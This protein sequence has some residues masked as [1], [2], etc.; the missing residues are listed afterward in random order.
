MKVLDQYFSILF[1]KKKNKYKGFILIFIQMILSILFVT[2]LYKIDIIPEKYIISI[3]IFLVVVLAVNFFIRLNNKGKSFA[4]SFFS[5]TI[6]ILLSF[7]I[8]YVYKI[9][10]AMKEMSSDD[11]I[12]NSDIEK[13]FNI[14]IS[15][16]DVYGDIETS[17]RSDVN[18]I[19][20]VN[21]KTHQILLT[22]TPRDFYV[23]IPGI[24]NGQK[25][26]LTHAGNYGVYASMHTLE[27]L[28][29]TTIDFYIRINFTS[30]I[31]IVDE[32]GGVD[33]FSEY[34]FTTSEESGYVMNIK[35]GI[36]HLNGKQALAFSRERKNLDD[37][38]NQ[39]GKNQEALIIAMINKISSP[40]II[41]KAANIIDSI[42]ENIDTNFSQKQIQS[43]I[44]M[45]LNNSIQWDV[46]S[47]A[48]EG[49]EGQDYCYSTGDTLLYVT[50]PNSTSIAEIRQKINNMLNIQVSENTL[51]Y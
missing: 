4:M 18:I 11:V 16:I 5:I 28:Y 41:V 40:K 33:V 25:D 13:T 23:P 31:E 15:G 35:K 26:K 43:L 9:N 12:I 30:L 3:I 10:Y 19:A 51:A 21:P 20:T 46:Q 32:L 2:S 37:G 27:E 29:K 14:Y 36:N 45:Q 17:S 48:A 1:S 22:T 6:I 38:D 7:S 34:D 42:S 39:R 8:F 49:T 47:I 50:Y 24:S 44:K